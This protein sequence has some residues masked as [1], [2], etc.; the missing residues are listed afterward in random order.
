MR[1]GLG[2]GRAGARGGVWGHGTYYVSSS[3]LA[4]QGA[5]VRAAAVGDGVYT[6]EMYEDYPN[7]WVPANVVTSSLYSHPGYSN[8]AVGL[9][10]SKQPVP[11]D[12]GG[13]IVVQSDGVY[14]HGEL[15]GT[16]EDFAAE[17]DQLAAKGQSAEF[18]EKT[19]WLP[20]GVFALVE[21]DQTS[22]DDIFE[23]AV[24]PQGIIR[25][26]YH[27]LRTDHVESISGSVEK[28]TQRAAWVIGTDKFPVYEAGVA[29]LTKDETPLLVHIG[30]GQS[31][32]VALIRL[33]RAPQ[34]SG[35]TG[36][37]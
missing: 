36:S 15:A 23:I 6:A 33:Q 31:R 32:Q 17:A 22:S 4:A 16:P 14:A 19:K 18:T 28:D 25:G 10:M 29:N 34:Q 7:A 1:P 8:L 2:A 21:G 9:G 37:Q 13:N 5:A 20:L 27:D 12:Y 24:N 26:N 3:A 30:E 35:G 11:Y